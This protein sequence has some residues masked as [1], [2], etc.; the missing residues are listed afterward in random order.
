MK[1]SVKQ[2]DAFTETPLTGNP[3]GVVVKADGL[4][5]RQM[6]MVAREMSVPETA[7]ILPPTMPGA[8]LRIR[9]FSPTVEVPLCGH[10][11]IASFHALAESNM[12]GMENPGAYSFNLET[13]SGILPVEVTKTRDETDILFG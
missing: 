11:T 1:I 9:W 8:D 12:C 5:D 10:A 4:T 7:F 6:Q 13:R 3:A 2:V